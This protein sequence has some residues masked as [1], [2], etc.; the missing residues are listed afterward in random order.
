MQPRDFNAIFSSNL[1]YFLEKQ[2]HTQADLAKYVGVSTAAVNTWC[3]GIKTPRM[4]KTD[5]ICAFLQIKRSDLFDERTV[6]DPS[7]IPDPA[8]P[9]SAALT[10]REAEHLRRYR[11]I[12]EEGRKW[13]DA[14]LDREYDRCA[15]EKGNASIA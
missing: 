8:R 5:K 15:A 13:V 3:K 14:T 4:D 11:Y 12:D 6:P 7:A 2:G 10:E 1:N 9:V